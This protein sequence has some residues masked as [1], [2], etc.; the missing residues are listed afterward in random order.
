MD[1]FRY[2]YAIADE[3]TWSGSGWDDLHHV[4]EAGPDEAHDDTSGRAD[5]MMA[6]AREE[7]RP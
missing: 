5:E 1:G 2:S 4:T 3:V 7:G 6:R